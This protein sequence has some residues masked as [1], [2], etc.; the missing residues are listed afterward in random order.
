VPV[1]AAPVAGYSDELVTVAA[2]DFLAVGLGVGV[3]E[4]AASPF[5]DLKRACITLCL[6][7]T[8]VATGS[9]A[10]VAV[11][12]F[13]GIFGK[14]AALLVRTGCDAAISLYRLSPLGAVTAYE[15]STDV[16]RAKSSRHIRS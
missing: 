7:G 15:L 5:T 12:F 16:H 8:G 1:P 11:D 6:A 10:R 3:G 2:G 4:G 9:G 13:L 14:T